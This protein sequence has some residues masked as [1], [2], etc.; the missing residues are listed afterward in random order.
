MPREKK[1][2]GTPPPEE[3]PDRTEGAPAES[4]GP[5]PPGVTS[6]ELD[7]TGKTAA[8]LRDEARARGVLPDEGSGASGA[9]VRADLEK[10]LESAP[11]EP[12]AGR[13]PLA[14]VA[15]AAAAS[16]APRSTSEEE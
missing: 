15:V 5:V 12:P 1:A 13:P 6:D 3:E 10:A 8:E 14:Q 2:A 11:P 16:V 9:V 7:V 4:E